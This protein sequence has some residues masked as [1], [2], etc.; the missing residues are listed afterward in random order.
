[1]QLSQ[2][3]GASSLLQNK[4]ERSRW[5]HNK[6][7]DTTLGW[8]IFVMK[9]RSSCPEYESSGREVLL[10]FHC[11]N[12]QLIGTVCMIIIAARSLP[13]QPDHQLLSGT[14]TALLKAFR[15]SKGRL[16]DVLTAV[17]KQYNPDSSKNLR[18][19]QIQKQSPQM[20]E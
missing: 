20:K 5:S 12:T 17:L 11:L 13:Y 4:L 18:E 8:D 9:F 16:K 7:D 1:M 10:H 6:Y 19:L 3:Q 2:I 15:T 14:Y